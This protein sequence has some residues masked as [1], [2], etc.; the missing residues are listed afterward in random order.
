MDN[1]IYEV[2]KHYEITVAN[3][4]AARFLVAGAADQGYNFGMRPT[5]AGQYN[6]FDLD[7]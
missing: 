7:A 1:L 2:R 5:L 4:A 6:V 3:R